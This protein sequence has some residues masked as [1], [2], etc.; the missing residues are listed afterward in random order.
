[1]ITDQNAAILLSEICHVFTMTYDGRMKQ[2]RKW[3]PGVALRVPIFF[4]VTAPKARL[5]YKEI[6]RWQ[7]LTSPS[8]FYMSFPRRRKARKGVGDSSHAL[9]RIAQTAGKPSNIYHLYENLLH[10]KIKDTFSRSLPST[11][12]VKLSLM[13]MC[14]YYISNG[15]QLCNIHVSPN[16]IV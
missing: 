7:I 15:R 5:D 1:M 11:W 12:Q 3:P 9:P 8:K 2:F 10:I 16:E 14:Y 4:N 6:K 13:D